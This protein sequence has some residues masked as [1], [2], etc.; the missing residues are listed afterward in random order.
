MIGSVEI[1][2]V[3]RRAKEAKT[4]VSPELVAQAIAEVVRRARREGKTLE[5]LVKEILREDPILDH[6][7]RR[8]LSKIITRAWESLAD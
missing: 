2:E 3:A 8:W 5:E 7:Q 4:R 1:E 6:V